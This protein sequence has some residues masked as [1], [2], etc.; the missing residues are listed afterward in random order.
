MPFAAMTPLRPTGFWSYASSDD[1]HSGGRLS[2]LRRLLADALQQ[3]IGRLPRVHLFQDV[4]TIPPG[5]DWER[6]IDEAIGEAS[7]FIPIVTPGFLQS[8]WCGRE[9]L[10]FANRQRGM[11]RNDLIFPI[12]YIDVEDF[13][14]IRR[15]EM[16]DPAVLTL[17]Q[18]HQWVDFR[19]LEYDAVDSPSVRRQLGRVAQGVRGAL[20]RAAVAPPGETARGPEPLVPIP[21][22]TSIPPAARGAGPSAGPEPPTLAQKVVA[23][24]S[25]PPAVPPP[26]SPQSPGPDGPAKPVY[27]VRAWSRPLV[28]A[29]SGIAVIAALLIYVQ[30]GNV[31]SPKAPVVASIPP[32]AAQPAPP[33]VTPP[34]PVPVPPPS[35]SPPPE[36][37]PPADTAAL[38]FDNG[39]RDCDRVCPRMVLIP[40]GKFDMGVPDAESK[41]EGTLS[42][43][44]D[45]RPVHAVTIG[46]G[47]YLSEAPVTRGEYNACVTATKC[48]SMPAPGFTQTDNDPVV[49]V[50]FDDAK[51][52][53]DWLKQKTG[54]DYRL[55]S[56]AEW[57]YAA[58][59]G[60]QTARY[61]GDDFDDTGKHTVPRG[62]NGTMP[63][64]SFP[65]N[66]FGLFDM[67]GHVWQWTGDCWNA[68]YGGDLPA[69][70]ASRTTGDCGRRVVRGGSW[71]NYPRNYRAG[72]RGGVV[73]GTRG[74]NLG[75]RVARTR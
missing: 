73:A 40:K 42:Q 74:Y 32:P 8:E 54:Q 33:A 23:A 1:T 43:D 24:P 51:A 4:H 72:Y 38:P 65:P 61:W 47:F 66:K 2:Q 35:A 11:G 19:E 16:H 71:I 26:R 53:A 31:L 64:K 70:E 36:V 67:L 20:F 39:T 44:T 27:R 75:F 7:F 59:A 37:P 63:V 68:D 6:Q 46:H 5:A 58:R 69:D 30:S 45:A 15:Q 25:L 10:R 12:Y 48:P 9:V 34:R 22:Q 17:L 28:L 14:G 29:G 21:E 57:E 50:S 18:K 49:S 62:K 13:S 3:Q 52:Y 56:E 60:T 55:P 41:R